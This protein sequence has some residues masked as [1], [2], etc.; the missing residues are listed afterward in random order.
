[1]IRQLPKTV[2]N[3]PCY[4]DVQIV[5]CYIWIHKWQNDNQQSLIQKRFKQHIATMTNTLS[6]VEC[7]LIMINDQKHYFNKKITM[8]RATLTSTL[9]PVVIELINDEYIHIHVCIRIYIY[10]WIH[11]CTLFL[12]IYIHWCILHVH[13]YICMYI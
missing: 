7:E 13:I 9:S 10:G 6:L 4:L 3:T 1:M 11:G 2:T 5:K 8:H 12:C